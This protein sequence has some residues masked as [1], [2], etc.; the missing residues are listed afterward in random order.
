MG[1]FT[2]VKIVSLSGDEIIIENVHLS[3]TVEQ[4]W[5]SL[6]DDLWSNYKLYAPNGNELEKH[7]IAYL[8]SF[9]SNNDNTINRIHEPFNLTGFDLE[10]G[11]WY[12]PN[13]EVGTINPNGHGLLK[14]YKPFKLHDVGVD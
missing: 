6:P 2:D 4:F 9:L 7:S 8:E 14:Q 5:K 11:S 13:E 3:Q 12:V 1:I 10:Y